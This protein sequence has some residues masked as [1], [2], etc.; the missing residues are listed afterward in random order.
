MHGYGA[1]LFFLII[2][3]APIF[4]FMLY[5]FKNP[6]EFFMIGRRHYFNSPVEVSEFAADMVKIQTAIVMGIIIII[7]IKVLLGVFGFWE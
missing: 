7:T 6:E 4:L 1:A 2:I 5:G 3:G